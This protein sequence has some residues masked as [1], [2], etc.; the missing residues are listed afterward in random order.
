MLVPL[1]VTIAGVVGCGLG[2]S[3]VGVDER[4]GR[5]AGEEPALLMPASL[6]AARGPHPRP[7]ERTSLTVAAAVICAATEPTAQGG[8]CGDS[9]SSIGSLP[10]KCTEPVLQLLRGE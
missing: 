3:A 5:G 4:C 8:T 1:G 10:Q 6:T 2:P 7:A 9:W